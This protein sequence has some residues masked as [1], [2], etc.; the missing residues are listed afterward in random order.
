VIDN[1]R[2]ESTLRKQRLQQAWNV[3]MPFRGKGFLVASATTE[4]DDHGFLLPGKCCRM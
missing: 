3:F 1:L 2:E 4:G